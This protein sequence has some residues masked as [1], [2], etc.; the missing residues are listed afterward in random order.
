MNMIVSLMA[1]GAKKRFP[2]KEYREIRKEANALFQKLTEENRDLPKAMK[3]HTGTNIFPAIAVYKTLLA[4]G[5]TAED[6]TDVIRRFF[7]KICKIMFQ[8]VTWYQHIVGNY[9][10]YPAGMVKH[11]LRDFSPEAG[12]E[13]RIGIHL[14]KAWLEM[15]CA[16]CSVWGK[17]SNGRTMQAKHCASGHRA[18]VC[19]WETGRLS[20]CVTAP[21]MAMPS[22]RSALREAMQRI[23]SNPI[24]RKWILTGLSKP[25]THGTSP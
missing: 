25:S 9:H 23:W 13:Y 24:F 16:C 12:F 10:R 8:P 15:N 18:P 22:T 21:G 4:H 6:A 3:Q 20:A 17:G 7:Y 14:W 5:M 11:S 2:R 19:A 1:S